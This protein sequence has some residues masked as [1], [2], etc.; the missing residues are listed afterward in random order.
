MV[1][2][3]FPPDDPL[4]LATRRGE[5]AIHALHVETHYLVCGEVTGRKRRS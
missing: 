5:D 3:G 1:R 4:L 2:K